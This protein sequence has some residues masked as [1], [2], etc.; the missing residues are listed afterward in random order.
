MKKIKDAL[1]VVLVVV[2]TLGGVAA[3]LGWHQIVY[4][5]YTCAFSRCV[6]VK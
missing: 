1:L 6:R 5:D 3:W 2:A 4:G